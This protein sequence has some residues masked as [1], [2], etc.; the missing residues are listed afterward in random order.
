MENSK[1]SFNADES[2]PCGSDGPESTSSVISVHNDIDKSSYDDT[3]SSFDSNKPSDDDESSSPA[4]DNTEG[5]TCNS[6][7]NDEEEPSLESI[8]SIVSSVVDDQG[9]L[10]S[11]CEASC[12]M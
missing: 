4:S 2:V 9:M 6:N 8:D 10:E 5:F 12:V 11:Y 7:E 3:V 1:E